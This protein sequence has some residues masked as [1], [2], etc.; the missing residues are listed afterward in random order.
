MCRSDSDDFL[1]RRVI[2]GSRAFT[3]PGLM[4]GL[5]YAWYIDNRFAS[6]IEYKMS[7]MKM[8]ITDL[9]PEQLSLLFFRRA[10]VEFFRRCVF[11]CELSTYTGIRREHGRGGAVI[12]G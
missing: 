2:G 9:I 8:E 5:T 10:L 4:F 1:Y 11:R 6:H 12:N 3:P 7:I